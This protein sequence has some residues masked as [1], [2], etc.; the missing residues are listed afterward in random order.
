MEFKSISIHSGNMQIFRFVPIE[1]HFQISPIHVTRTPRNSVGLK[2]QR[3]MESQLNDKNEKRMNRRTIKIL[4]K[5]FPN[6]ISHVIRGDQNRIRRKTNKRRT[7]NNSDPT[8]DL[9]R[10][11]PIENHFQKS[12]IQVTRTHGNCLRPKQQPRMGFQSISIHSQEMQVLRFV[13]IENHFQ[14]SQIQVTRTKRNSIRPKQQQR[15]E[16]KSISIHTEKNAH[17]SI[18]S[19]REP[20]S[21][22]TNSSDA[23]QEKLPSAAGLR[24]VVRCSQVPRWGQTK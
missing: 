11:V 2:Q 12:P 21:N 4:K 8:R 14:M 7:I 3:A 19:N 23:H 15:M 17:L 20:L 22:V 16:S 10:F 9:D 6:A 24:A 18:R 1:N 13:A 5:S